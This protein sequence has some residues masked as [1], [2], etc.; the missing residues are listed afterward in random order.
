MLRD[1]EPAVLLDEGDPDSL[2]QLQR[3]EA[4]SAYVDR[5]GNGGWRGLRVPQIQVHRFAS[6][7]LADTVKELWTKGIENPDVRKILLLLVE[8]GRIGDCADIAHDVARDN[9]ASEVERI[10][11]IDAMVAI[12]D[13]RLE[14][15][16]SEVANANPAWPYRIAQ[17]VVLRLFPRDLSI[18]RFCQTLSWF[19]EAKKQRRR[20][21]LGAAPSDS[22]RRT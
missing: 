22:Q 2:S 8:A 15:V 12:R 9:Q 1:N 17:G 7:G 4:L 6:P 16:A 20:L 14:N 19:K 3:N 10:L 21:Q 13:P 11:A 5:Y 18:D